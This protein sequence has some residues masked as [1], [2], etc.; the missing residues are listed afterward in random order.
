MSSHT[1]PR[2]RAIVERLILIVAIVAATAMLL[3]SLFVPTL[4]LASDGMDLFSTE[5][6]DVGPLP[7]LPAPPENSFIYASDGSLLDEINFQENR[8]P[9]DFDAIPDIV[10]NAVVATED[11]S[12]W[13]HNGVNSDAILRSA[14]RNVAAGDIVGGGST[15]T[16][17]YIKNA[18]QYVSDDAAAQTIERKIREAAWAV[19]LEQQ[20]SKDEILERYLNTTFFGSGAWGIGTAAERYFSK[21]ISELT[22]GEAATLAGVIRAPN[23]NNPIDNPTNAIERRNIVLTQMAEEDYISAETRDRAIAEDLQLAPSQPAD[24]K[25]PFWTTWITQL[26]INA[27]TAESLGPQQEQLLDL[28]GPDAAARTQQVYQGGLRIVTT[29]DPAMQATATDT[30]SEHLTAEDESRADIAREP[31]GG[32]LTL[33][34]ANGAIRTM[35]LGPS[36]WGNCAG[37][38]GDPYDDDWAGTAEDGQLLCDKTQVNPLIPGGGG[39]G[40][41]PG[42][43]FKA[44]VMA[45]A[46]EAGIPPGFTVVSDDYDNQGGEPIEVCPVQEGDDDT[47]FY[48]PENSSEGGLQSMYSAAQKSVNVYFATL[49]GTL[50]PTGNEGPIAVSRMAERLGLDNWYGNNFVGEDGEEFTTRNGKPGCSVALGTY[51]VTPLEMAEGYAT[52]ANG[53]SHCAPYAI[54]RIEDREGNVLWEHSNDCEQVLDET[55]ATRVT[56]ILK[57]SPYEG[58][59]APSVGAALGPH[60]V[61]GKT[62]TT[63]SSIDAWFM[64]FTTRFV[65]ASWV[66]YPNGT[67]TYDSVANA[68]AACPEG[69]LPGAPRSCP[70]ETRYMQEVTVGGQFYDSVAGG[71][72]PAPMWA[73]Y[74]S[75]VMADFEPEAF[76]EPK[77]IPQVEVPQLVGRGSIAEMTEVAEGAGLQLGTQTVA[78]WQPAGTVISQNPA[79]GTRADTGSF[80]FVQQSDGTAP[81]PTAPNVVGRPLAQALAALANYNVSQFET[82]TRNQALDG[83]V[84]R[85]N[86][87]GGAVALPGSGIS[88][89]VARYEAPPE[90]AEP[91]APTEPAEPAEP[92][93]P[94]EPKPTP[95]PK[96]T[97]PPEPDATPPPPDDD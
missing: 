29:L 28:M 54:E 8:D 27:E 13:E 49:T 14:V 91:T 66:G 9:V 55:V 87:V 48:T 44:F 5:I 90:P 35:A 30:I 32:L 65:T 82:I 15:I 83:T 42:S 38:A 59:T 89:E 63:N 97:K 96:P 67:R 95:T 19:Q 25:S 45:A 24:P 20:M 69:Q 56:D 64:G 41:Q 50:G 80:V 47:G 21:D 70:A 81:R 78:S 18:Y 72:I 88:I 61:R 17:Q 62:G 53:G 68:V 2:Y 94:A 52:I 58:G 3:S 93:D 4:S 84:T 75:V 77:P 16:Q 85:Q 43:S 23:G 1:T 7:D 46:L 79:A 22:L 39:S 34:P 60:Q 6:L 40:R 57:G 73:D 10:V 11:N 36:S 26:L 37:V 74:M 76:P 71:T 51:E 92:D 31:M 33:E 12:F 86:P